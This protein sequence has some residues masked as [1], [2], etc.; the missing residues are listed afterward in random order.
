[1]GLHVGAAA[2]SCQFSKVQGPNEKIDLGL[3]YRH[4]I[5]V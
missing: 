3:S 2:G 1:M 5:F 4:I